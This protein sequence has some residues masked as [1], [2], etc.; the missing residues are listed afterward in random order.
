MF[1]IFFNIIPCWIVYYLFGFPLEF[2]RFVEFTAILILSAV[3]SEAFGQIVGVTFNAIN[4]SVFGPAA[5]TP[6]VATLGIGYDI[7]GEVL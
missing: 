3:I 5:I 6:F 2:Y 1:Q 4:G 7:D